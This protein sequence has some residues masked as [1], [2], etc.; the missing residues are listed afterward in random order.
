MNIPKR[1]GMLGGRRTTCVT[2]KPE[3]LSEARKLNINVS[4][5]LENTLIEAIAQ[6][7]KEAK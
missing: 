5:L 3:V 1:E 2:I 6:L 7:K 4:R